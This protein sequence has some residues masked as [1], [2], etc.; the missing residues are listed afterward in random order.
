M[1]RT[2]ETGYSAMCALSFNELIGDEGCA[3]AE[4]NFY[5]LSPRVKSFRV[6][7]RCIIARVRACSFRDSLTLTSEMIH[8]SHRTRY[9]REGPAACRFAR[10]Q[11]RQLLRTT[12]ARVQ[13]LRG[14]FTVQRVVRGARHNLRCTGARTEIE[15]HHRDRV[16][17]IGR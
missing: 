12:I 17:V 7:Y 11:R 15:K 10:Y 1:T 14:L 9:Q 4:R 8:P 2:S 16:Q 5:L 6:K 13:P 3:R